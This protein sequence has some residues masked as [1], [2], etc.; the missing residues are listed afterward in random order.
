[1]EKQEKYI[2]VSDYD[3]RFI[4]TCRRIYT[5]AVTI[6]LH[7]LSCNAFLTHIWF[8]APCINFIIFPFFNKQRISD[9]VYVL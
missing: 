1:M 8:D 7:A 6:D 4:K 3:T 2:H 9:L 5:R